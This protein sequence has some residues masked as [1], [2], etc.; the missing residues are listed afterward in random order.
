MQKLK[1]SVRNQP[2]N[3]ILMCFAVVLY[4][5]NNFY[6]KSHTSGAV[7]DFFKYYFNDLLC[8]FFALGYINLLLI[9]VNREITELWKL[10]LIIIAAGCVWETIGPLF[11]S[12][13]VTDVKDLL[14]YIIGAIAYWALLK[15]F[16]RRG[17]KND[18]S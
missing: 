5:F 3:L 15:I 9:T 8:P 12:S 10:L 11:K 7:G 18:I 6:I 17:E 14:C 4:F 13:A 16:G 2:I 1:M